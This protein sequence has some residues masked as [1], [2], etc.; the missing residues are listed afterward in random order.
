LWIELVDTK[1]QVRDANHG[2]IPMRSTTT[3]NG[4]IFVPLWSGR[5]REGSEEHGDRMRGARAKGVVNGE[6]SPP[7]G[8][9]V[10]QV[11][12]VDGQD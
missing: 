1:T 2:L 10:S 9:Y 12:G 11:E 5:E 6:S 7:G 3:R 8:K 4:R